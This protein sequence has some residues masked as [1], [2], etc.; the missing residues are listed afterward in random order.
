M[1]KKYINM[2]KPRITLL[3]IVT[4]YLGYYLGVRNNDINSYMADWASI[5]PFLHLVIGTFLTSSGSAILNQYIERD[6]DKLMDRTNSRPLPQKEVDH[7]IAL[8]LGLG[9]SL[10]GV[11]YLFQSLEHGLITSIIAF[12]TILSYVCIYTP[13]KVKTKWNTIIGA[14]PG[15][16]PPLGG[17]VAATGEIDVTG[18]VLFSILFFWQMPHFYS[19]A[20]IYKDDYSKAGFKMFPS[21]SN[22]LDSTYFQIIFFTIALIISTISIFFVHNTFQNTPN[23]NGFVYLLGSG[24]LGIVFLIYSALVI[25]KKSNKRVKNIFLFSIIYLPLL[26]VLIRLVF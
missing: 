17:W 20:I 9:F 7:R 4:C 22:N 18:I 16:L 10:F 24:L 23:V 21:V 8:F 5:E 2:M 1:L 13:L 15:A 11:W 19:L 12:I 3:V 14:F 26:M 6:L 25:I